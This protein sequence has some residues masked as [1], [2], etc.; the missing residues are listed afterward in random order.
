MASD[1][2]QISGCP[3]S[4]SAT[5]NRGCTL[6]GSHPFFL[7]RPQVRNRSQNLSLSVA[8]AVREAFGV[9]VCMLWGIMPGTHCLTHSWVWGLLGLGRS[10]MFCLCSE[11]DKYAG[12]DHAEE[13]P[14]P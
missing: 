4:V 3:K 5:C 11:H 2:C 8:I 12:E 14:V 6:S 10:L 1:V 13:R 7:N 9:W